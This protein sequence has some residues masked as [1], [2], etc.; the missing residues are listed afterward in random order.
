MTNL[1]T[2]HVIHKRQIYYLCGTYPRQYYSLYPC[3]INGDSTCSNGGRKLGVGCTIANQC[4]AYHSGPVTCIQGCCCTVQSTPHRDDTG[5]DGFGKCQ[6]G[7]LSKVRCALQEHCQQGQRCLNGLC[8]TQTQD[9]YKTA[10]GGDFAVA[11]C[12]TTKQC[13]QGYVCASN[14]YCCQCAVGKSVGRCNQGLC[15]QGYT[16]MENGW[17]CASCPN[18]VTPY[19]AC[20]NNTCGGGRQCSTGNICC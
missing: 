19:G 1:N 15:P 12:S 2:T 6:N 3:Y 10:C 13:S 17:C 9:E 8:C 16:C 20:T 7:Q 18:N 14:N 4:V 11:D 5:P